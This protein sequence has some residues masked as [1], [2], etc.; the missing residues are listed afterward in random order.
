MLLPDHMS[1]RIA[2][3][4]WFMNYGV[5]DISIKIKDLILKAKQVFET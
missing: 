2:G 3:D 4:K 5:T 1:S